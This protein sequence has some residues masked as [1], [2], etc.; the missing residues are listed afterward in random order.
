MVEG[1]ALSSRAGG[2][3]EAGGTGF[4]DRG[5]GIGGIDGQ[6]EKGGSG[7]G[8]SS[9]VKAGTVGCRL[10]RWETRKRKGDQP[11]DPVEGRKRSGKWDSGGEA[12]A[13]NGK[14]E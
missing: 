4:Q 2:Q 9:G 10:S 3:A 13:A 6:N 7:G 14:R 11:T 1:A 8:N 12:A 5:E